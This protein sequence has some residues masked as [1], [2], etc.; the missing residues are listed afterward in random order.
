MYS[1]AVSSFAI[2]EILSSFAAAFLS[3]PFP[4]FFNVL[5]TCLVSAAGGVLYGLATNAVMVIGARFL[6]GVCSGFGMVFVQSYIGRSSGKS[7]LKGFMRKEVLF[8]SFSIIINLSYIT[9]T[10]TL[11]IIIIYYNYYLHIA[12]YKE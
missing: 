1:L 7:K 6:F 3:Q 9:I 5:L 4:Y 10:G 12:Y 2:G 11:Y 8:L